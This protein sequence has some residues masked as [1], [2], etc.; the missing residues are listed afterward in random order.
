MSAASSSS[1][2]EPTLITLTPPAA[3]TP[4]TLPIGG[5]TP[6]QQVSILITQWSV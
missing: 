4:A 2:M 5:S 1:G 3:V 6:S